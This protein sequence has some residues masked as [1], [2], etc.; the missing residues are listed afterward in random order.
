MFHYIPDVFIQYLDKIKIIPYVNNINSD[1][2]IYN[3]PA[4]L[5]TISYL[6]LMQLIMK[7]SYGIN[8]I[9]W[10]YALPLVLTIVE[11]MQLCTFVPGT[12]DALDIIVYVIPIII[13]L[14]I[15][16]QYEKI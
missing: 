14:L 5:W 8:R 6:I 3:F 7:D 13:S 15:D 1:F 11:I 16:I 2:I 12:F 4:G 10:I 9:L